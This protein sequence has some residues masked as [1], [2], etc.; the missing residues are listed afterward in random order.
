MESYLE[1]T[2]I[3][4][5]NIQMNNTDEFWEGQIRVHWREIGK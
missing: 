5:M 2:A 4:R 3:I 1:T